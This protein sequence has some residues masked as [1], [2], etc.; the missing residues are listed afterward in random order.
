MSSSL[1][2]SSSSDAAVR[3]EGAFEWLMDVP[4]PVDFVLGTATV[5]VRECAAFAVNGI[6]RLKQVAGADLA[7]L[8]DLGLAARNADRVV[9]LDGGHV[10]AAGSPREA[11]TPKLLAETFG[12]RADVSEAH[13][14]LWVTPWGLAEA[15]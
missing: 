9:V 4:C 7:V 14:G 12:V 11:L 1:S 5:K 13:G 3:D 8:H 6:V 15:P 10:A 2:S